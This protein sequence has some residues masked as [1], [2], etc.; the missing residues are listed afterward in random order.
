M[1]ETLLSSELIYKGRII[2]LKKD[3]VKLP[4]GQESFREVAEHAPAAVILPFEAPDK[5][6]L[7]KQYRHPLK[8]IILEAPA[9]LIE[10]KEAPL[11]A[12]KR[13]L[14]EETGFTAK[15][16]T[17]VGEHYPSPGFCDECMHFYVAES[18]LAGKTSFDQDEYM[19]LTPV[20]LDEMEDLIAKNE[21]LDGK[22][23]LI[24]LLFRKYILGK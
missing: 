21:I 23:M 7:V 15:K 5:I 16:W 20:T 24:Y 8:K 4:N 11:S 18:L 22:T 12:A 17:K 3:K 13:E 6:F 9:G 19:E 2:T 1:K 10:N 14:Q